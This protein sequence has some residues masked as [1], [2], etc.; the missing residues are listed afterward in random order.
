MLPHE[1]EF[2]RY[3]R[4][5]Y[6]DSYVKFFMFGDSKAPMPQ[7]VRIFNKVGLPMGIWRTTPIL[8]TSSA[9]WSFC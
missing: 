8:S 3:D 4:E 6:Y 5:K 2:P 1:C 7:G 9:G